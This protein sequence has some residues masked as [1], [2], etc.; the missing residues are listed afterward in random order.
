MT[1][2]NELSAEELAELFTAGS[3]K[4]ATILEELPHSE[5]AVGVLT[6]ALLTIYLC[7][8]ANESV[9]GLSYARELINRAD[10]NALENLASFLEWKQNKKEQTLQ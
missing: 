9:D 2:Q 7:T 3:E 8:A 10:N 5:S 6:Q 4:A 1:T